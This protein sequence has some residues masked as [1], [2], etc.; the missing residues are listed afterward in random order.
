MTCFKF[1]VGFINNV[2]AFFGKGG[3][4]S[5]AFSPITKS[6]Q[7]VQKTLQGAGKIGQTIAKTFTAIKNF[8]PAVFNI[9]KSVGTLFVTIGKVL[10]VPLQIVIGAVQ[11]IRGFIEGFTKSVGEEGVFK[12]ILIGALEGI[13][14]AINTLFMAPLDMFKNFIGFLVNCILFHCIPIYLTKTCLV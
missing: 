1:R 2:K 5:K 13:K 12:G 9:M 4:L 10:L 11:F 8:I 14:K 7:G 3:G 6:F